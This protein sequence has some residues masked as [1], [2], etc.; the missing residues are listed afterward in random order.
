MADSIT[1]KAFV[2]SLSCVLAALL[3]S[4]CSADLPKPN[5]DVVYYD[6]KIDSSYPLSK[7]H[8][9]LAIALD[10][11]DIVLPEFPLKDATLPLKITENLKKA[12]VLVQVNVS[13][14]FLIERPSAVR[15]EVVFPKDAK[16]Y[17]ES[18]DVLRGYIRTHYSVEIIDMLNNSLVF[19][20][21][22]ASNHSIETRDQHDKQKNIQALQA[23]FFEETPVARY[24]LISHVLKQLEAEDFNV[25]R[26]HFKQDEF[27]IVQSVEG[28]DN[29][30]TAYD[31]LQENNKHYAQQALAVYNK[32]LKFYDNKD[33][34]LSQAMV[35]WLQPGLTACTAIVNHPHQDRYP[36]QSE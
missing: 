22:G 34:A 20:R 35:S 27:N 32:M 13:D 25:L 7:A 21:Q 33:D 36:Y 11:N 24:D 30:E 9:Y 12:Q 16:G 1:L 17:V 4:A 5:Y 15:S 31:L 14:S 8:K 10:A 3:L 19:D 26:V 28:E 6:Y 29:F 18:Y 23:L 2:Y